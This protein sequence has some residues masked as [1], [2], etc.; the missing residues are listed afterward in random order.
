MPWQAML[1]RI[2]YNKKV[3]QKNHKRSEFVLLLIGPSGS[4]KGTQADFLKRKIPRLRVIQTG[5]MLRALAKRRTLTAGFLRP[6]LIEGLLVP[7]WLASFTWLK[8]IF[9][10]VQEGESLLFDGAPR[11]VSEARLLDSVLLWHKK[12]L[13]KAIFLDISPEV[14]KERL[15][16]RGRSDDTSDA[17]RER[18]KFYHKNVVPVIRYYAEK[19]RLIRLN[20]NKSPSEIS[21]DLQK[22]LGL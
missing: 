16:K 20:A 11:Q 14:A 5:P 1:N 17:I 8:I 19:K 10:T 12:P 18:I 13:A 6:Y 4:G 7:R 22:A 3:K 2:W 15:L 9:E 21:K